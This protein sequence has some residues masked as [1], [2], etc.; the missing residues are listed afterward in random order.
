M[1]LL[2]AEVAIALRVR[3]FSGVGLG[4]PEGKQ[5]FA[6]PPQP[7]AT[8]GAPRRADPIVFTISDY[9]NIININ[10]ILK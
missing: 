7:P 6:H 2:P 1:E 8:R 3:R 9:I 5:S 10:K 4:R